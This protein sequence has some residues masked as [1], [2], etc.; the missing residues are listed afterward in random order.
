MSVSRTSVVVALFTLTAVS[1]S[2]QDRTLSP[3]VRNYA[4]VTAQTVALTHVKVIDGTAAPAREDQTIIIVGEQ[5]QAVGRTGEVAIPAGAQV[6]DLT[7]HTAIPG[8][9]GLHDHMYYSSAAGGSMK[10]M[11]Q[12]YPRLFLGAGVTTIRTAGSTDSYQELN[13]KARIDGGMSAGP[14]VAIPSRGLIRSCP[15]MTRISDF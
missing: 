10:M 8:L 13:L 12:S 7:G 2:A 1:A 15:W 4:T 11:L 9:I 5:I 14:T 3:A 6:L